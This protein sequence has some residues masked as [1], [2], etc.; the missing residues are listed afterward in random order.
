MAKPFGKKVFYSLTPL[1]IESFIQKHFKAPQESKASTE[2]AKE[3]QAYFKGWLK[4]MEKG[5]LTGKAYS[6]RTVDD[7]RRYLEAF[8]LEYKALSVI[9]L[10]KALMKIAPVHFSKREHLYKACL[11]F[12]R[13][14]VQEGAIEAAVSEEIKALVPKRH[15]P[16]KR[17][18]IK[19]DELQR[20]Y[21]GCQSPQDRAIVT[22]L[23]T[24]GLRAS[25]ACALNVSDIELM[26]GVLTVQCAKGG[27]RRQVGLSP[28][29][30][31]ALSKQIE[32]LPAS[33]K[34][35]PVFLDLNGKR[36]TPRGLH[37]RL[38]RIGKAVGVTANPHALRRAFVT[39]NANKGRPL[40]M[41][42]RACGHSDIKTTMSYCL[43]SEQEVVNAMK[44]W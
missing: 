14:L 19:A 10:K 3:H 20:L 33:S 44:D 11:C 38:E 34:A 9:T 42:Q 28:S 1:A 8:L 39:I 6:H 7:Y 26:E 2:P 12:S 25:E 40:Q 36:M 13:Y 35:A 24:T 29:A 31:A 16:P 17:H 4:A 32:S 22:L 15:L 37:A 5:T 43:T 23:S 30:M 18:T 21:D 27:K 41:L